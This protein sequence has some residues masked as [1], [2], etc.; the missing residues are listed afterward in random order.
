MPLG[1]H[2][3]VYVL[4]VYKLKNGAVHSLQ[5]HDSLHHTL[6]H[7]ITCEKVFVG[8]RWG[9]LH[10]SQIWKSP[11]AWLSSVYKLRTVAVVLLCR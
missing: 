10:A 9:V 1:M 8:V 5:A 3:D 4:W 7:Q 2:V 11:A 6:R